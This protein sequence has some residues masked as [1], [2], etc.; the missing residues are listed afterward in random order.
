MNIGTASY[1]S[2]DY[3]EDILDV[4]DEY[5]ELEEYNTGLIHTHHTM[6]AYF[7]N[8]DMEELE[9]NASLYNFY[10]SLIVND[11]NKFVAKLA[12]PV[13]EHSAT[14]KIKN[15]DGEIVEFKIEDSNILYTADLNVS[16]HVDEFDVKRQEELKKKAK[17]KTVKKYDYMWPA[18]NQTYYNNT[19]NYKANHR[20]GK[21]IIKSKKSLELKVQ[22]YL[23]SSFQLFKT[24]VGLDQVAASYRNLSDARFRE[25]MNRGLENLQFGLDEHFDVED[26]QNEYN[27]W[28]ECEK[29]IKELNHLHKKFKDEVIPMLKEVFYLPQHD[30]TIGF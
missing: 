14:Q 25:E 27:I 7:S 30:Y 2:F 23:V 20:V 24:Q 21:Q 26:F 3:S 9:D 12:I 29:Q 4:Y 13:I 19:N 1:T 8:T 6:D 16:V 18:L 28:L 5:P 22:E 17:P 11:K 10:L 15:E